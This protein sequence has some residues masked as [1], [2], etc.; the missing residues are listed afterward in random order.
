MDTPLFNSDGTII[1]DHVL[2]EPPADT[3]FVPFFGE[4]YLVTEETFILETTLTTPILMLLIEC[5]Q[6]VRYQGPSIALFMD[7]TRILG[8]G[9]IYDVEIIPHAP[10]ATSD[11]NTTPYYEVRYKRDQSVDVDNVLRRHA[12]WQTVCQSKFKLFHLVDVS[13]G[14][15]A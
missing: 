7:I 10:Y 2:P 4:Q 14:Q 5:L 15:G 11:S 3:A 8:E 1:W 9:Y 6:K 13:P 12:V